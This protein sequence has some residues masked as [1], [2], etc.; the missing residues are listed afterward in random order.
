MRD[1][2]HLEQLRA[3]H[4]EMPQQLRAASWQLQSQKL[5]LLERAFPL[6]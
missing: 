5:Q 6:L 4:Y 2:Q 3:L 1:D